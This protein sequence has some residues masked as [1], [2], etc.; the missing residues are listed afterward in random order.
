MFDILFARTFFIVGGM[1]LITALTARLNKAFKSAAEMIITVGGTFAFLFLVV[2]FAHY[3]PANLILVAVFSALVGWQIGPTI[4]F[5]GKRFK[6][7]KFLKSRGITLN[8]GES[9]TDE[10]EK[11]FEQSFDA[12]SYSSEWHNVVFQALFA[13][14]CAVF[15]TV[16]IVFL[17]SIDFSFLGSFLLIALFLL[18]VLGLLNLFLFRSSLFSLVRAYLGAIIFVLYLLYDFYRLKRMAGDKSWGAAI[19]IAVNIYLDIINL[20]LNLLQLLGEAS[21]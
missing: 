18:I 16:G 5:F 12:K 11:A 1:L 3:Y 21:D 9:L 17:T 15:A 20:F 4:E 6:R 19:D 2:L 10:Q 8:K 14:S 13:T 7:N